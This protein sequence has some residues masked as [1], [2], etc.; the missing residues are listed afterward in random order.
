MICAQN[1][2]NYEEN[3]NEVGCFYT[4]RALMCSKSIE[5]RENSVVPF[6]NSIAH[7]PSFRL[8]K[9]LINAKFVLWC[10]NLLVESTDYSNILRTATLLG[11][12]LYI[13][14]TDLVFEQEETLIRE[15]FT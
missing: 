12:V 14:N 5:I 8:V 10:L 11:D 7:D 3:I 13:F 1:K 9:I 4:I 15:L 2:I 6:I